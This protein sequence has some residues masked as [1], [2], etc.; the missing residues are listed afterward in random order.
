LR[1]GALFSDESIKTVSDTLRRRTHLIS[2]MDVEPFFKTGPAPKPELLTALRRDILPSINILSATVPEVKALLDEAE[3]PVDYPKS[4]QDV[5]TMANA[6]RS[7]GPEYVII[8]R[9]ILEDGNKMTLLHYV[10]C[11]STEPVMVNSRSENPKGMFGASYSIPRE[12]DQ[13]YY[14]SEKRNLTYTI[15]VIAAHLAK[16]H[17]V[18][19]AVS[20][21]FK[22]VEEM[23]KRGQYFD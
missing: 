15:A 14:V 13:A 19:E 8:K 22:F 5:L 11:G 7:L 18:P 16:G 20:A 6:L 21:G 3:I 23:L 10:L 4:V 1:I 17:S 12:Y 9:E 2:V